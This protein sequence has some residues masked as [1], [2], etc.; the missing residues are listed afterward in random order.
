[1][2]VV[3]C[4]HTDRQTD[5]HTHTHGRMM[6]VHFPVEVPPGAVF[7]IVELRWHRHGSGDT[8]YSQTGQRERKRDWKTQDTLDWWAF[9]LSRSTCRVSLE[10][11][12]MHILHRWFVLHFSTL[13]IN[14]NFLYRRNIH[15]G[16]HPVG[17][18]HWQWRSG[19]CDRRRR[20]WNHH[21][22]TCVDC[23]LVTVKC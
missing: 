10:T 3:R 18:T 6:V 7:G 16:F 5:R 11:R 4:T 12:E 15:V 23:Q 14:K 17:L 19:T 2:R 22:L 21:T 13:Y 8:N 20:G 9:V 1:M